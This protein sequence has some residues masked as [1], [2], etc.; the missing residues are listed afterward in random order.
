MLSRGNVEPI[1]HVPPLKRID[2]TPKWAGH[3]DGDGP[4]R[5]ISPQ[6]CERIWQ[7]VTQAA[8]SSQMTDQDATTA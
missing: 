1:G 4:G 8:T 3:R 5:R 2:L 6:E 7:L